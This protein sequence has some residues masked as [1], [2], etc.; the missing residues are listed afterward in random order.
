M[1]RQAA[2]FL[3]L[4]VFCCAV[5][6]DSAP[7]LIESIVCYGNERTS[8][9]QIQEALSVNV[10]ETLNHAS[11][12]ESKMRLALIGEFEDVEIR[13]SKGS[14][15]GKVVVTISVKEIFPWSFNLSG[16]IVQPQAHPLGLVDVSATHL[17]LTGE[18]DP[19]QFHART[20]WGYV[21]SDSTSNLSRSHNILFRTDY[22]R[23]KLGWDPLF[24]QIGL[25]AGRGQGPPYSEAQE[26]RIGFSADATLGV[27]ILDVSKLAVSFSSPIGGYTLIDR[28]RATFGISLLRDSQ[29]DPN[30]PTE[31][32]VF[33]IDLRWTPPIDAKDEEEFYGET[34]DNRR[35]NLN[36][37][38]LKHWSLA[39]HHVLSI[40][41]GVINTINQFFNNS[42]SPALG[43]RYTYRTK[44]FDPSG[45]ISNSELYLEPGLFVTSRETGIGARLGSS[46]QTRYGI[47]NLS[48]L[49]IFAPLEDA[50]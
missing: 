46:L 11:I 19:L 37:A 10:G 49:L 3:I 26:G 24:A 8:C 40:R 4:S 42:E 14:E 27:V 6:A 23:P 38:Y 25:N 35:F 17:N 12:K 22:T 47:V 5:W 30:F 7:L 33:Q 32:S 2:K 36:I 44:Q 28:E 34:F 20:N 41:L 31:G 50:K 1:L 9:E 43:M 45:L 13:L 18:N 48:A 39:A 16:T 29:D 15:R 21:L